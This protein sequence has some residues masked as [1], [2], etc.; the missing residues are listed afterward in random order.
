MFKIRDIKT[1]VNESTIN[2]NNVDTGDNKNNRVKIKGENNSQVT[3]K[4]EVNISFD[5]NKVVQNLVLELGSKQASLDKQLYKVRSECKQCFE[6]SKK[7]YEALMDQYQEVQS[8]YSF[9]KQLWHPDK[10]F[11]YD[12]SLIDD[13]NSVLLELKQKAY[14]AA[15]MMGVPFCEEHVQLGNSLQKLQIEIEALEKSIRLI[16]ESAKY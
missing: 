13:P 12:A 7:V 14:N 15:K 11:V 6:N 4:S 8:K 9:E 1:G 5:P 3:N 16:S 2:S 10:P